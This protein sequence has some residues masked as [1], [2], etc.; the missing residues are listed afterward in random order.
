[1]PQVC[2]YL[3][4][5]SHTPL[6]VVCHFHEQCLLGI[7]RDSGLDI[8]S[9]KEMLATDFSSPLGTGHW[10][11]CVSPSIPV[12]RNSYMK[13]YTVPPVLAQHFAIYSSLQMWH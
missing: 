13:A 4:L 12:C 3:V 10:C 8:A 1:M 5:M 2:V 9:L 7:H 11:P 6:S